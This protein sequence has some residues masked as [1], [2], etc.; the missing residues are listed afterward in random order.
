VTIKDVIPLRLPS[1]AAIGAT[2]ASRELPE[3]ASYQNAVLFVTVTAISG[4]G[5]TLTPDVQ[6][7][8]P[9]AA[10]GSTGWI[11]LGTL[12]GIV[13]TGTYRYPIAGP[14]GTFARVNYVITGSSPS[15][16]FS[17]E[18]V[19]CT[20]ES[21]SPQGIFPQYDPLTESHLLFIENASNPSLGMWN[22]GTVVANNVGSGS[23]SR[24]NEVPFGGIPS[25]RLDCQAATT[26]NSDPGTTAATSGIVF[27]RR[28]QYVVRGI[29]SVECWFRLTSNNVTGTNTFFSMSIYNRDGTNAHHGRIWLDT[30]TGGAYALKYL[31]SSG[32]WTSAATLNIN[33]AN[34]LYDLVNSN[35]DKAGMWSYWKLRYDFNADKY[36]DALFNDQYI[37][38]SGQGGYVSAS[39]GAQAMHF[40]VEWAQ[41]TATRRYMNVAQMIGR[42]WG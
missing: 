7:K 1:A 9:S 6:D 24:D 16:T 23:V 3:L 11:S 10:Y 18:I 14:F 26:S 33:A 34:H 31:N 5:A 32:V 28:L 20:E 17:S 19:V 8:P 22:D 41:K 27:K 25:Y 2:F 42:R 39:N 4:S 40:S 37:D 35:V 30:A 29:Y 13:A 15:A 38:L 12:T 36:V 21:V